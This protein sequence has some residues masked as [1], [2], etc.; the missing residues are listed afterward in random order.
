MVSVDGTGG[1][2]ELQ[3]PGLSRFFSEETGF[4]TVMND[5]FCEEWT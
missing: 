1:G 4:R 5:N 3:W 2:C